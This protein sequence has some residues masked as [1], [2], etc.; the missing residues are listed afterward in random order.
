MNVPLNLT[1]IQV[2][3]LNQ[4]ISDYRILHMNRLIQMSRLDLNRAH[5]HF[6]FNLFNKFLALAK[7]RFASQ[8]EM[9]SS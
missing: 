3:I 9:M 8:N 6:L 4:F 7:L 5:S 2:K 1:T